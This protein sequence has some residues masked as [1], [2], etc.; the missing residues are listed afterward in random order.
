MDIFLE[1]TLS[2]KK[3]K[4]KSIN[5]NLIG[6]YNCG[7][8]VYD[9][10]HI[11]NLRSYVFADIL[12]RMFEYNGYKVDQVINITDIGHLS[13]DED[14]GEDKMTKALKREGKPITLEAMREVADFYFLKFKEDLNALNIETP[15]HFPFAS[16]HIKEDIEI[17]EK[18]IEKGITY[19]TSDGLYF[20]ISKYK[21][22]G[23]LGKI[24]LSD[25]EKS[26]IG[27]NP[28]KKNPRDF[29][30]WKFNNELGYDAPFGKGF[31]GWHIECS[32]MSRKYLGQPFDIHT[33]GIDHI[34]VHHNNEIAQSESAYGVPLANY[35]L[36][37]AFLN[38]NS[39]KMAK[40]EGNYI[41]L[42]TLREKN[43]DPLALRYLFLTARYSSQLQFSWEALE[44]AQNALKR[45]RMKIGELNDSSEIN[46]A[47]KSKFESFV[48]DDLDTAKVIAL[49]SELLRDEHAIGKKS[50]ILNFDKILG[51]KLDKKE[52]F[53]IPEHIKDMILKRE[54]ARKNKDFK[55]S[56]EIRA[57]IEELGFLVNDR[58]E[59][60]EVL[61]K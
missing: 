18:L 26:R 47:Y 44:G 32:A 43:V 22:Y 54:E 52:D 49:I 23:K 58:E 25:V 19:N 17:I 4:F 31:P 39:A 7:P 33:G 61:P 35:W 16:D 48:N 36:H 21:D 45:L 30:L 15:E 37:N 57:Q 14:S 51:L 9:Y 13:S 42:E 3:E 40:S 27:L 34:P 1:N 46:E 60:A 6:I 28:E 53:E 5:E 55:T 12:R 24:N 20:D 56:D 29:A 59:G 11:G 41:T 50:T 8:T 2:G 10:A 38:V